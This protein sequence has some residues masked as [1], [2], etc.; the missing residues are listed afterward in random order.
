M[1]VNLG[2]KNMNLNIL[3]INLHHSKNASNVFDH[4]QR[5]E[6]IH[7]GLIT[8]PYYF[9]GKVRNISSG[10][11]IYDT[12]SNHPR[13]CISVKKGLN[14][15][16]LP[17][18]CS[19]DVVA[20]KVD[21][22][23]NGETRKVIL[24]SAYFDA[25]ED[26]PIVLLNLM[27][28]CLREN[29][30]LLIGTD[31]NA[32]HTIW[33]DKSID[34]RGEMVLDFI[35]ENDLEI[36][37]R[38][39]T[40][41]FLRQNSGTVIDLTLATKDVVNSIENWRVSNVESLS[42]HRHIR[43]ELVGKD[44]E[45]ETIRVPENT[46]WS[47]YPDELK[48][49]LLNA[50]RSIYDIT[51]LEDYAENVRSAII[52]AYHIACPEKR[53]IAAKSTPWWNKK[54]EEMRHNSKKLFRKARKHRNDKPNLWEEY[55]K[56]LH[57]YNHEIQKAKKN[58]WKQFCNK[59][60]NIAEGSRIHKIL[61]KD[62]KNKIGSLR[63]QDGTHTTNERETLE[64]LSAIHF[65]GSNLINHCSSDTMTHNNNVELELALKIFTEEKIRWS[66]NSF[67]AFKSPGVDG[68][69]P[70]LLQKASDILIPY[71]RKLF[72]YSYQ[73]SYIPKCWREVK[74]VF[75]PKAGK[76]PSDEAKSY[77]PISLTSFVLKAMERII[78]RYI[79]DEILINNPLSTNQYAY[80]EG[81]STITAL[82][83]FVNRIRKVFKDKEIG[84]ATSIDIEG[85]FDNASY[86]K[87]LEALES[88]NVDPKTCDWIGNMLKSRE[89]ITTLGKEHIKT[90]PIKGCPQGG[91]LSP[92]LW[93]LEKLSD[94]KNLA[95]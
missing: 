27:R 36:L 14:Y 49:N 28:M 1:G 71:L 35:I 55:K 85:A 79:R 44:V 66:I 24:C 81:K 94:W 30:E 74:V 6:S 63:K 87:I 80:Q 20:I 73:W 10:E 29:T 17:E 91:V 9:K 77:R 69:F 61:S 54:L 52:E 47:I 67:S 38:G 92:L 76:R 25:N 57:E 53:K 89:I 56:S 90:K 15:F 34:R 26:I 2:N 46:D 50:R 48:D 19:K 93:C 13:A 39:Y 72:I 78:D 7:I 58:N 23:R 41:T 16:V 88:K 31:S 64:L 4:T 51:D 60:D 84:I 59:M 95:T 75:I 37:N 21:L 32:H 22:F 8:E 43:Y 68:I 18:F 40:P 86:Q 3:Q 33:G 5:S 82:Q 65:P 42:D 12:V 45:I 70:A 83:S 11:L 62:H